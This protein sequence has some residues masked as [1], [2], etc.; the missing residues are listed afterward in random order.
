M[1]AETSLFF[2]NLSWALSGFFYWIPFLKGFQNVRNNPKMC[3]CFYYWSYVHISVG[4]GKGTKIT[5]Y[6][7]YKITLRLGC[8]AWR[9]FM[10]TVCLPS[11]SVTTG[12]L[13]LAL[14]MKILN[15]HWSGSNSKTLRHLTSR[16][17]TIEDIKD[18]Y[19]EAMFKKWNG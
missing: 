11:A 5:L 2:W 13:L 3:L 19:R 7:L 14:S 8:D 18:G 4:G 17:L 6:F 12:K 15:L 9:Y 16:M 10:V 1:V